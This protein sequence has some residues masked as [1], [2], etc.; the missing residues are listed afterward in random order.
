MTRQEEIVQGIFHIKV[1]NSKGDK[2]K[3]NN[4]W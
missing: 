3:N 1:E 2:E 4:K